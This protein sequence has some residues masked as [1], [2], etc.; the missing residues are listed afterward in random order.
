MTRIQLTPVLFRPLRRCRGKDLR[1]AFEYQPSNPLLRELLANFGPELDADPDL[2]V[3][4]LIDRLEEAA[5]DA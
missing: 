4:E 2:R 3:G 5:G 1:Q